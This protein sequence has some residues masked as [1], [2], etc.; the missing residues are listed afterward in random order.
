MRRRLPA[1]AALAGVVLSG[2]SW[3]RA[4]G[5]PFGTQTAGWFV[6][7]DFPE[8]AGI[9][10][11]ETPTG[12][13][14]DLSEYA[15]DGFD[16]DAVHPVVRAFYEET[17]TFEM[18]VTVEWH[19]PFRLGAALAALLTSAIQQLNLPGPY[20]DPELDMRSRFVDVEDESDPREDVRAWVRT[21]QSGDAVFVAIYGS[22]ETGGERF[23]NVGVPLP[24]W[25]LATV[26]RLQH[27]DGVDA[28][29]SD[30]GGPGEL[31]GTGIEATTAGPGDPGL[32]AVVPG[33]GAFEVP[34][35]QRFRVWPADTS[36]AP[37]APG[38][39]DASG[40]DSGTDID[41]IA[42]HEMWLFG[43][44]FLTVTYGAVRTQE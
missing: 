2:W 1:I 19:R 36:D 26:L 25:N 43:L 17:S 14:D 32:Y 21:N 39:L 8:R 38:V 15:R 31:E 23:V 7:P 41:L 35:S 34:M 33:I 9:A 20:E 18:A 22:H 27:F 6:G 30:E 29:E 4:R 24:G 16:P 5:I 3:L 40:R 44:Q 37:D 10:D 28:D 11:H 13:M 12:E 42:T